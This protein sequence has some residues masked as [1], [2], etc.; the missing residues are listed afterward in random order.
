MDYNSW[1]FS[2]PEIYDFTPM[3]ET[4]MPETYDFNDNTFSMD[5]SAWDNI[6]DTSDAWDNFID[7]FFQSDI[8]VN[9]MDK[10][11]DVS[12]LNMDKPDENNWLEDFANTKTG[13]SLLVGGAEGLFGGTLNA[14]NQ[15]KSEDAQKEAEERRYS[16]D[17]IQAELDRAHD[18]EM[19]KMREEAAMELKRAPGRAE[20]TTSSLSKYKPV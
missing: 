8:D 3:T 17:S 14:I 18:I 15:S 10:F 11:P 13:S 9:W 1:D 7:E 6:F 5:D 2:S 16:K 19:E 4:A 12:E 20:A